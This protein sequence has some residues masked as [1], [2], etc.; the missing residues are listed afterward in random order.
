MIRLSVLYPSGDDITFDHDYYRN[1]HV[2]MCT[3]AW[4]VGAEIDK[5]TSGPYVAAV[6]FF[7][8]SS[9]AMDSAF[10]SPKMGDI[11]GDLVNYTNAAPVMQVSEI[12]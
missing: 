9:E 11:M 12:V 8:E 5:G 2:P 10:T 6:H 1:T 7:F 3:A 4:N